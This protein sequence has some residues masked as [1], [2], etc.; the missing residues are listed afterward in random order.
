[1]NTS[2]RLLH[3]APSEPSATRHPA[4]SISG[5][6]ATPLPSLRFDEGQCT[7]FVPCAASR[8]ISCWSTQTQCATAARGPA[9]PTESR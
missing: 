5:I 1:M 4:W 8:A 7:T 3:A 6:L 9:I 2:R